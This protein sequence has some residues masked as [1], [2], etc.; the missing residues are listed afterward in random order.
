MADSY[1][2]DLV[3]IG[4]GSAGMRVSR[5]SAGLGAKVAVIEKGGLGGTCVNAG[6]VPKKLFVHAAEFRGHFADG[7]NFGWNVG[8]PSH[9]FARFMKAMHAQIAR[10]HG[11]YRNLLQEANVQLIE[12]TARFVKPHTLEVGT[13]RVTAKYVVIA[14]GG[15]A[16][17]PDVP[18]RELLK[19]SDDMFALNELPKRV[20]VLGGGYIGAEFASIFRGFGSDVTLV[21]KEGR[22][23]LGFDEEVVD[24][25]HEQLEANGI[26]V[27]MDCG[28][29][30]VARTARGQCATLNS[31][32][33]LETDLVLA[34]VGRTPNSDG[35]GLEHVGVK[36]DDEGAIEVDEYSRTSAEHVYAIGDVTDRV[37]LTPVAIAE[38]IAVART[39]F[40]DKPTMPD[41]DNVP[42]AVFCEPNVGAVGLTERAAREQGRSLKIFITKFRSLKQVM[43]EREDR[44]FMKLVVDAENDRVLGV[45]VAGEQAAEMVQGFAVA[46]KMGATKA[47]FDRTIGIHPTLA[48]ELLTMREPVR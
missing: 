18:G 3:V 2:F 20:V 26:K 13:R 43:S 41:H 22:L 11:I 42:S 19:T 46:V 16:S 21:Q 10:L 1:D 6:C 23:L 25:V 47:A 8:K 39:L 5:I 29:T 17:T 27:L 7:E 24:F 14:T 12:G 33:K 28:I 37:N 30:Q 36:R 9:D 34:A 44:T 31:G 15:R 48:E 4:A 38:G 45:H 35:L 32:A 40:G